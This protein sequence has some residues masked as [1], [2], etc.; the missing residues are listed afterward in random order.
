MRRL[1]AVFMSFIHKSCQIR[2]CLRKEELAAISFL[3]IV[4]QRIYV[5]ISKALFQNTG[6][7]SLSF[8]SIYD[9]MKNS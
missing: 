2:K 9:G 6:A 7:I 1:E 5:T 4:N 8:F 3:L